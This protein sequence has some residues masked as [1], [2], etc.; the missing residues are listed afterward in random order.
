MRCGVCTIVFAASV[1]VLAAAAHADEDARSQAAAERLQAAEREFENG[2]DQLKA[3]FR[4]HISKALETAD[5]IEIFLLEFD[6]LKPDPGDDVRF[7]GDEDNQRFP[8]R[9]YKSLAKILKHRTLTPAERD[10]LLPLL[11]AVVGQPKDPGGAFC[12][13]PIHG[14][15]VFEGE[16]LLFESS[17]CYVCQNFYI[18]YPTEARWFG[19]EAKEFEATMKKLMPIPASEIER[20]KSFGHKKR[21]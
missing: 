4:Q 7:D 9:P 17:F 21:K 18:R 16:T 13:L 10:E 14:L 1:S 3:E 11:M 5:K 19:L 12:H 2:L 15:R 20:V 8:I 6:S